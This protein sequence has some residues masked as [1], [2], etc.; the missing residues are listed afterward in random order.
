M[1]DKQYNNMAVTDT[2]AKCITIVHNKCNTIVV[3]VLLL[4]SYQGNGAKC[5][6][7]AGN[8]TLLWPWL[9]DYHMHFQVVC[10]LIPSGPSLCLKDPLI[11]NDTIHPELLLMVV[12]IRCLGIGNSKTRTLRQ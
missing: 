4:W 9:C 3:T 5:D 1:D 10:L 7:M 12:V 2:N 8:R 11:G 6:S